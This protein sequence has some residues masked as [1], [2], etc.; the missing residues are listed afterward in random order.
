MSEEAS[1]ATSKRKAHKRGN[2]EGSIHQR[3]DELWI[4]GLMVD[5]KRSSVSAKTRTEC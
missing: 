2:G 3:D 4:G 1:V 5:R